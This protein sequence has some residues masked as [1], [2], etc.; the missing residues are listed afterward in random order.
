MADAPSSCAS[1]SLAH[2]EPLLATASVVRSWLLLEQPG[3]WGADALRQSDLPGH[4]ADVLH[5]RSTTH[6]V[7]VVLLRRPPV[8]EPG[9]ATDDDDGRGLAYEEVDDGG[10]ECFVAHSGPD[11]PWMEQ[12]RLSAA[13]DVLDLDMAAAAAGRRPGFGQPSPGPVYLVCTNSRHDPCCGR[14]GR[15]TALALGRAVGGSVWECSHIGGERF[16]ANL[17][18]FPHGLYFGR[19]EPDDGPRIAAAYER[20]EIDLAHYRGRAG[21]PFVVQAA[22]LLVR[23]RHG[24]TAVDGLRHVGHRSV[25]ADTVDVV[26]ATAGGGRLH[27]RVGRTATAD[28]RALTCHAARPGRPW[29]YSLVDSGPA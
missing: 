17:V 12:R 24:L 1:V 27:A 21:D 13:I 8:R 18:C 3:P 7:R 16:A 5:D 19:V 28:A 10:R 11:E 23:R 6:D 9:S 22:D 15:P 4:V 20:G 14:L 25:G 29:A 2:D 26:F